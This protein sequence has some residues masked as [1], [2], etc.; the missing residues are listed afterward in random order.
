MRAFFA[1]PNRVMF[2]IPWPQIALDNLIHLTDLLGEL[3]AL[4]C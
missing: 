4:R 1:S 2:F 3:L